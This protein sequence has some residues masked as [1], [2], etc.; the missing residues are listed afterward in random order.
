[1]NS[2]DSSTPSDADVAAYIAAYWLQTV[3]DDRAEC[4]PPPPPMPADEETGR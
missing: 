3:L 1:M 2:K 4:A